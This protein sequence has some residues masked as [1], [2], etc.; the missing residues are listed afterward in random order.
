MSCPRLIGQLC[1]WERLQ[2]NPKPFLLRDATEQD[3]S[4]LPHGTTSRGVM[5]LG[6]T[7]EAMRVFRSHSPRRAKTPDDSAKLRL[8]A[9][10][11]WKSSIYFL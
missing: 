11:K 5:E 1:G 2:A 9:R 8:G 3:A 6:E 4:S 7:G 10:Q